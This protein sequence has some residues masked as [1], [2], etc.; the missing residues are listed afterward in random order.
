MLAESVRWAGLYTLSICTVTLSR[1]QPCTSTA[2]SLGAKP[3]LH[4]LFPSVIT[5][6]NHEVTGLRFLM[7]NNK[8]QLCARVAINNKHYHIQNVDFGMYAYCWFQQFPQWKHT[9]PEVR[10]LVA[11][12]YCIEIMPIYKPTNT[13]QVMCGNALWEKWQLAITLQP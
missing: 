8:A 12:F 11:F 6:Y 10:E 9:I 2:C 13:H 3:T 7:R 5:E 1:K 4:P